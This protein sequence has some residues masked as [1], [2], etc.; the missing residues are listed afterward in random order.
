LEY[1]SLLAK[2]QCS[3]LDANQKS[4]CTLMIEIAKEIEIGEKKNYNTF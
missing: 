1:A 3:R 4:F 2:F